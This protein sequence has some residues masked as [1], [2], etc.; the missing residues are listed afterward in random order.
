MFVCANIS[1][2][3]YRSIYLSKGY[4]NEKGHIMI[5]YIEQFMERNNQVR[6]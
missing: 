1:S 4:V 3:V 6:N 2:Q 5:T